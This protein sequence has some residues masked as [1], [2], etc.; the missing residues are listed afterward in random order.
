MRFLLLLFLS[1]TTLVSYAQSYSKFIIVDQFGYLP[2]SKK[3]AVLKDPQVGFD[4]EESYAPGNTFALVNARTNEKV[5]SGTI[6][7]WKNGNT[8]D[9]SGDKVSYFDFSSV[10]KTGKYYVLDIENNLRSYEFQISP[11]VYNEVLKQA[12]R[13]FFYQRAGCAK[14]AKYAGEAWADGASHMGNHQDINCRMFLDKTNAS[15]EHNV[16]GGWYD[17]GDYN[18]YTSWTSSYIVEMMWAYQERPKA[19]ADNY[20]IPESGNGIPDLLDEAKWGTDHLLRLQF[21]DGS[22]ISIVGESSASPPSSAK[23]ASFYGPANTSATLNAA[24]ALAISSKVFRQIGLVEYADTLL[25]AAKKAYRWAEDNPNVLFNNNSSE[26]HSEGLGAGQ[27]E[28]DDYGRLTA[29]LK[30]AAFL[31]EITGDTSYRDFF[32]ANYNNVHLLQW[33]YAYP[34]EGNNQT[35]LLYYANLPDATASVSQ[36]IKDAYRNAMLG[37]SENFPAYYET[38]DPYMAH[39]KEYTW[40]S[41]NIKSIQGLMYWNMVDYNVDNEK[42]PDV[43]EAAAGYVHYINGVNPLN[44]VYL[45]N[46]YKYGGDN[47]VN[48]FYHSWFTNG[49]EKWDRVG[50]STYGPAPGYLTGGPNPGYDWDGCCPSGCGSAGNNAIC[51]SE[52]ISPPK[53]QPKQKSYKDFNTSWPLNSWSVTENSCGYQI[54]FIRLLS[55]YVDLSYDCNGDKD[56]SAFIDACGHCAGGNTGIEPSDDPNDCETGNPNNIEIKH[57]L[58]ILIYPNPAQDWLTIKIDKE[59]SQ[60]KLHNESG[61]LI[62]ESCLGFENQIDIAYLQPGVYTLAISTDEGNFTQHFIKN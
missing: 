40:G 33:N 12:V 17:A 50:E 34:F 56:G 10:Q 31:F 3:V 1:I 27:M 4:S 30:A 6:T 53:G 54:N 44:M 49:S 20:N 36:K 37:G 28:T 13:T 59:E 43:N 46:M 51:N 22:V 61:R 25:N 47:C 23:G 57:L 7:I 19:W 15:L 8:D 52:S 41:N 55:K 9:S 45:S 62:F 11:S 35:T 58:N 39:L 29:K 32:D 60:L 42:A 24:G 2:Q 21:N 18:K 48:E 38:K 26:Y 5:Y 16:N 14:D